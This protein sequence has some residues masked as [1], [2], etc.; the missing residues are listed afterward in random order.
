MEPVASSA[1]SLSSSQVEG[2]HMALFSEI[3][4]IWAEAG[5]S[6]L[7]VLGGTQNRSPSM[8]DFSQ[9]ALVLPQAN[10]IF[11]NTFSYF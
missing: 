8:V 3:G 6:A 2:A 7:K 5:S 1:S 4:T 10:H 9:E 11:V